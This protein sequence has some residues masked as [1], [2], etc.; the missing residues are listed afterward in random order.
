MKMPVQNRKILIQRHNYEGEKRS[1]EAEEKNKGTVTGEA[2][3][4]YAAQEQ[5]KIA[6]GMPT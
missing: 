3:N 1:I 5:Q 2:L 6:S 4:A